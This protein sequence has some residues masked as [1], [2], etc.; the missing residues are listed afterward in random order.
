[1]GYECNQGPKYKMESPHKSYPQ[2]GDEIPVKTNKMEEK[3]RLR[4]SHY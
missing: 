3:Y 2:Q 4:E 1:M